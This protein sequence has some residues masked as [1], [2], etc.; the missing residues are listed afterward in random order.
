MAKTGSRSQLLESAVPVFDVV[1]G[2]D[3]IAL[4]GVNVDGPDFELASGRGHAQEG[5]HRRCGG[6]P[7]YDEAVA[8]LENLVLFPPPV[9]LPAISFDLIWHRR[10]D[11]HPAQQWLRE[12]VASLA[13]R[14]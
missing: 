13:S 14:L 6:A 12:L 4:D 2:Y 9:K 1:A 8:G 11:N 3:L 5:P 10:N 7:T